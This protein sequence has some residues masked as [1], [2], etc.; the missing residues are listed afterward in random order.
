MISVPYFLVSIYVLL[1]FVVDS[2]WFPAMGAAS[3]GAPLDQA[4]H[5]ILLAFAVG[6]GWVGYIARLV[7]SSMIEVMNE[8]HIRTARAFGLSEWRVLFRYALPLAVLPAVLG[9]G[10]G[11]LFS[12]VVLAEVIFTR[13]GLGLLVYQSVGLRN[14][15]IVMGGVLVTTVLFVISVTVADLLSLIIDPRLRDQV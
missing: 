9:S 5:L 7:R 2:R 11:R 10:I 6:L 3:G 14:Y 1:I 15:P 13:P 4:Y 12:S 8:N